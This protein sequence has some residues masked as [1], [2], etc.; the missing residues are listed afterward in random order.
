[1]PT[2]PQP[3]VFF[4]YIL[5]FISFYILILLP[6]FFSL[7]LPCSFLSHHVFT[8]RFDLPFSF[9]GIQPLSAFVSQGTSVFCDQRPVTSAS[10]LP[11]LS[12]VVLMTSFLDESF[13]L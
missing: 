11:V 5:Q 6:I 2:F 12:F 4:V 9:V 1:L 13:S 7:S 3:P 8:F 10:Y